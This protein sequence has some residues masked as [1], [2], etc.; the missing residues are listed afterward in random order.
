MYAKAAKRKAVNYN[1]LSNAVEQRWHL[2][3]LKG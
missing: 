3:F 1:D 2:G